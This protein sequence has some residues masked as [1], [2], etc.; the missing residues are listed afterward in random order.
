MR[1]ETL[2]QRTIRARLAAYGFES[3]HV[4]NG[5]VLGGERERRARQMASLKRDGLRVG[6]PDLLVY[7]PQGR[8]GHIEVK[9]E[10]NYQTPAQKA[11]AAWLGEWGH[12]YAVCRSQEDVDE[13]LTKWGWLP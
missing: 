1:P 10:G 11:V 3:V 5:A 8:M 4:P 13:T 7:G 2:L 12:L 9:C 6:F